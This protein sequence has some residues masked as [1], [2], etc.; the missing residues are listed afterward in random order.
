MEN[1]DLKL[2]WGLKAAGARGWVWVSEKLPASLINYF[3]EIFELKLIT[4]NLDLKKGF[5]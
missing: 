3:D 2:Q 5:S 1:L 4:E